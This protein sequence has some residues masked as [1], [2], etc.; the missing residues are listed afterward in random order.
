MLLTSALLSHFL[1]F[2]QNNNTSQYPCCTAQHDQFDFW[3]GS[4]EVT[5]TSGTI[6][7]H[8]TISKEQNNCLLKESWTSA[9]SAFTG[10]SFNYY[11]SQSK[12]WN[13]LWDRQCGKSIEIKRRFERRCDGDGK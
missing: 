1:L 8:N 10:T 6:V 7:G 3:E 2:S 4:W 13:Q 12:T 5:D 9:K 11:D